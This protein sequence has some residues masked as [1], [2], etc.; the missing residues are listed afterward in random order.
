MF[1]KIIIDD[2]S[3]TINQRSARAR[4][5]QRRTHAF[6]VLLHKVGRFNLARVARS[7]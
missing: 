1:S 2:D 5:K 6:T 4:T 7:N 3:I